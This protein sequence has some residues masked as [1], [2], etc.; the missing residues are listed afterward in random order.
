MKARAGRQAQQRVKQAGHGGL[1][2]QG[3]TATITIQT[4]SRKVRAGGQG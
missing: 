3:A 2:R 1:K 4:A